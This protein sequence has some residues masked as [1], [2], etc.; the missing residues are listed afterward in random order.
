MK[1]K[2]KDGFGFGEIFGTTVV[3]E[4]GQV[5]ISKEAREKIK[6]KPG[7]RFLVMEHSG[8]I[9]LSPEKDLRSMLEQ[10]TKLLK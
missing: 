6:I 5:V 1:K 8:K 2:N 9:I 7:D 4:R 10:I 3:G